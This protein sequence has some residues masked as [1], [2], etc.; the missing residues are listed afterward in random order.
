MQS[1][2]Q[3]KFD[4]SHAPNTTGVVLCTPYSEM[5]TYKPLTNTLDTSL[6]DEGLCRDR[7]KQCAG[8]RMGR[9][10]LLLLSSGRIRL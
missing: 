4:L 3:I 1:I 8:R 2:N 5:L 9:L 7:D 6:L 10:V